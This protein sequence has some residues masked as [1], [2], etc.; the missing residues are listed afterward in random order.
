M[1][2]MSSVIKHRRRTLLF[3]T[4]LL[5]VSS[6]LIPCSSSSSSSDSNRDSNLPTLSLPQQPFV[7]P[8]PPPATTT[9]TSKIEIIGYTLG[10][11]H[12]SISSSQSFF[13]GLD[14]D[15]DG[16]V[17]P[18]ELA[19]YF[20]LSIGGSNLDDESEIQREV[21]SVM[22][23][24]DQDH[25]N[26]L[27]IQDLT[28]YWD[29]QLETLLTVEEVAEWIVYAVQLPPDIGHLFRINHVTGYDFPELVEQDGLSL[30]TELKI[31]KPSFRKRIVRLARARMLGIGSLPD[32][33]QNITCQV[34]QCTAL[35]FTWS[36]S[37]A[38]GFPVH[39]YRIQRRTVGGNNILQHS[40]ASLSS[41]YY[42]HHY[43]YTVQ[44]LEE[45]Q[46]E[47]S[48]CNKDTSSNP[49]S[50]SSSSHVCTIQRLPMKAGLQ[51]ST[52]KRME[53]DNILYD[54][55]SSLLKGLDDTIDSTSTKSFGT[56]SSSS[57][58]SSASHTN[59]PWMHSLSLLAPSE[60]QTIYVGAETQFV[61]TGV[62]KGK[63]YN[64][65]IQAW[66]PIGRSSWTLVGDS[67]TAV[68]KKAKCHIPPK[69]TSSSITT[70]TRHHPLGVGETTTTS[71]H[72]LHC[73]SNTIHSTSNHKRTT[74]STQNMSPIDDD[75]IHH[76][77][78]HTSRNENNNYIEL[79]DT[80][81]EP[82]STHWFYHHIWILI[83][84]IGWI[85]SCIV[86]FSRGFLAIT[87]FAA[88]A[89]KYR[90][91]NL[92]TTTSLGEPIFP[93]FWKSVNDFS[94]KYFGKGIFP[95]YVTGDERLKKKSSDLYD[96]Q[97][98]AVGL[99]GYKESQGINGNSKKN[100]RRKDH[101]SHTNQQ[102]IPLMN[103]NLSSSSKSLFG[104]NRSTNSLFTEDDE[105]FI[106]PRPRSDKPIHKFSSISTTAENSSSRIIGRSQSSS[107]LMNRSMNLNNQPLLVDK[108][109]STFTND[110]LLP[111]IKSIPIASVNPRRLFSRRK[112]F[113]F[114]QEGLKSDVP[115]MTIATGVYPPA[116]ESQKLEED[117]DSTLSVQSLDISIR[118]DFDRCN[119]CQ[120]VYKFPKRFR[121]HCSRCTATFCHKHGRI[122]H[123]NLISCKVP[124]DCVCLPCLQK[125]Y[126]RSTRI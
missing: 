86:I 10:D 114:A 67:I 3:I 5:Y 58:S 120:K 89:M 47:T 19:S 77:Y 73:P 57:L 49:F 98:N 38:K 51:L 4:I 93:W 41:N 126:I 68:W 64:Y 90:R 22:K 111:P 109:T 30:S 123:S 16:T 94:K 56:E 53:S 63:E 71:S 29:Q 37:Q 6:F 106:E 78:H 21:H 11:S 92:D 74:K 25:N 59:I 124:G 40:A 122:T 70:N 104:R 112:W 17:H 12:R 48:T 36:T 33:P 85:V 60:W 9:A 45:I 82:F 91:M 75:T 39:S 84:S 80:T 102:D 35:A 46:D 83:H 23:K 42:H 43:G 99:F 7:P 76:Q 32:A 14:T 117:R 113:S 115:P 31:H 72:C 103:L 66:S 97:I 1:N 108:A 100:E 95:H 81:F 65:R 69:K 101:D 34:E 54:S 55:S 24:L 79:D 2:I 107:V 8:P 88:A 87:A 52:S 105:V 119:T 116:R 110:E 44:T 50:S 18:D 62:E 61:D 27:D 15:H 96:R 125:E 26:A 20:K 121:H 118:D 13:Q 28:G